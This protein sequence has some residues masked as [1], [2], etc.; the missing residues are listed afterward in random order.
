MDEQCV[1]F[2]PF[3]G[4]QGDFSLFLIENKFKFVRLDAFDG[5]G[6]V[7]M[8]NQNEARDLVDF[9]NTNKYGDVSIVASLEN[10]SQSASEFHGDQNRGYTRKRDFEYQAQYPPKESFDRKR[11]N[12]E[13]DSSR[14][15]T[16]TI[17][18]VGYNPATVTKRQIFEDFR[19]CG[20]IKQIEIK[21]NIGFIQFDTEKDA[22][23]AQR[24]KNGY[25][26]E[27]TVDFV[28][29]RPLNI[30]RFEIPL[31]ISEKNAA[32][33]ASSRMGLK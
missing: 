22:E 28:A 4:T 19:S 12:S 31:I 16:K 7:V 11:G 18:V 33:K 1:R 10:K 14:R 25:R 8:K 32:E 2:Q 30:P 26:N 20:Y 27:L 17:K 6:F 24:I 15:I 21:D 29:N 9:L 5:I 13:T 23:T 3:I